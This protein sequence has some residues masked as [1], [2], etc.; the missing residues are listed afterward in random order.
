[1]IHTHNNDE[2]KGDV[3]MRGLEVGK[4]RGESYNYTLNL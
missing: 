3:D 2:E 4:G 1:M